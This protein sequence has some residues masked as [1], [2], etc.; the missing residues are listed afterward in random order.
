MWVNPQ[1]FEDLFTFIKEI[2]DGK[3]CAVSGRSIPIR[4]KLKISSN[5]PHFY[6]STILQNSPLSIHLHWIPVIQTE[7]LFYTSFH[8][9]KSVQIRGFFWS[10]FS[11]I[12]TEYGG[13]Q[14][15]S[16]FSSNAG[17]YGPKTTLFG[18]LSRSVYFS[19]NLRRCLIPPDI[20]NIHS[21]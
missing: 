20:L 17:K 18:H 13:I 21:I 15:L 19:V 11:C 2:L 8:C 4:M 1:L 12:R 7:A 5:N 3:L 14:H 10:V 16:V 9:V 6:W